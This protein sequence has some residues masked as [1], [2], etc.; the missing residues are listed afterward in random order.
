MGGASSTFYVSI[1]Q[2]LKR[3]IHLLGTEN[4]NLK[5]TT[6]GWK[7]WKEIWHRNN[8]IKFTFQLDYSGEYMKDECNNGK[9]GG[10]QNY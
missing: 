6:V 1:T 9:T 2:P 8:I 7:T 5:T 10:G 3:P 4:N